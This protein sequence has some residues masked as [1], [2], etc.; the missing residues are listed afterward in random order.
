[1]VRMLDC[2]GVLLMAGEPGGGESAG[3]L[4]CY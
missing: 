3:L 1:M 2:N 4:E